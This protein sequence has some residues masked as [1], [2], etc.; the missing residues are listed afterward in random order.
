MDNVIWG[1]SLTGINMVGFSFP[2][3]AG[4]LIYDNQAHG[5]FFLVPS[6]SPGP[7]IFNNTI[8]GN[9]RSGVDSSVFGLS[10][11][12]VAN[13]LIISPFGIP[14]I[15]CIRE[16][17]ELLFNDAFSNGSLPYDGTCSDQTGMNG[18]ISVD[19]LF[20]DPAQSD[21]HLQSIS[22]VI[23]AGDN[24]IP[25][26]PET[27]LEGN[28]RILDGN[29]DGSAVVD[30]GAYELVPP[31]AIDLDVK[32]DSDFNSINPVS[33]GVIP[34]AI[35]GSETFDVAEV[36]A[37]TLAF[38]PGG[39]APAHKKGGHPEDVN[40]DGLTDLVSH[41]RT[42]ETGIAFGD[43]EACVTG[44]LLDG[45]PLEGCPDGILSEEGRGSRHRGPHRGWRGR[46]PS[47]LP[48]TRDFLS[49]AC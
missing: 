1:N 25:G 41:Y 27:D 23:D 45:T 36:D 8:V 40:D 10:S 24:G 47:F 17:P 13:N 29:G 38:G 44:E 3:I 9:A 12:L 37:T 15:S 4:N 6:G 11:T 19:P 5:I 22:P 21:Y 26:L 16:P 43:S 28:P 31:I 7:V 34:V 14:A 39:A 49:Q 20:V 30:L 33:Q 18:N 2:L 32:P 35:L 42:E 46:L 48:G